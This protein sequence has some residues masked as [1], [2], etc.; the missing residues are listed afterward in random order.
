MFCEGERTEP[1]Y[2]DALKRQ[3]WVQDIAAVD[4]RVETGHGG[5]APTTLVSLAADARR[6]ALD[7]KGEI[8]A[9]LHPR[10][11][12]CLLELFQDPETNP[13]G[14][15]LIFTTHDTSLLNH[16]NRDEVWLTEKSESGATTLTALAEYGGDKVR[17]SLNLERAY[18]QGRFG[19]VPELDQFTLRRALGLVS[20]DA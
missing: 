11:S 4:L 5:L 1:E 2:P 19:A 10:L 14:A 12:A 3:P 7:E 13:Y 8:D 17:R 16:L 6:K 18:L 15:Q 20:S 9:S